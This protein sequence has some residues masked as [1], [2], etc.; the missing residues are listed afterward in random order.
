MSDFLVSEPE[1]AS[2]WKD[3]SGFLVTV[4]VPDEAALYELWESL[5]HSPDSPPAGLWREPDLGYEATAL[6]LAPSPLAAQRCANLPLYRADLSREEE[7]VSRERSLRRLTAEMRRT[8]QTKGLSVLAHGVMVRNRYSELLG[9][10]QGVLEADPDRWRLPSWVGEYGTRLAELAAPTVVVDRYTVMHDCGKPT[11]RVVS[12]EGR[13]HFPDHARVSAEIFSEVYPASHPTMGELYSL[14]ARLVADDMDIH[15]LKA[16]GV[17]EFGERPTWATHLLVGL[18]EVHANSD[19]FGGIESPGFKSKWR[20]LE[21]RGRALCRL[22][23]GEEV[24][25]L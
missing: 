17:A 7:L 16:D 8:E 13:V 14:A 12:D 19:M 15:L 24:E 21:R 23:F 20:T 5:P 3:R 9:I 25:T 2:R 18:A 22:A 10:C 1:L 6:W 11:V 4:S